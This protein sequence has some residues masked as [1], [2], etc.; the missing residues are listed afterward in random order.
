MSESNSVNIGPGSTT[1][2]VSSG[3]NSRAH[4]VVQAATPSSAP[5]PAKGLTGRLGLAVD[6]IGY[7][8]RPPAQRTY[9]QHRLVEVVDGALSDSGMAGESDTDTGAGDDKMVFL[10]IGTDPTTALPRLLGAMTAQLNTN[11]ATY[12]DPIRL[13]LAI[14]S[15]LAGRGANGFV[16]DLPSELGRLLD[17]PA[18]REAATAKPWATVVALVSDDLHKAVIGNGYAATLA[19]QLTRVDVT[20]KNF[21]ATAWLWPRDPAR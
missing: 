3:S 2:A 11:N 5:S 10:P 21:Q 6:V 1:G 12:A 15:G 20:V 13:R 7:T 9:L 19:T 4:G 16:G 14:G 18:L 8:S 17:A